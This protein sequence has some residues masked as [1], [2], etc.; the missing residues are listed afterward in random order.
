MELITLKA[1]PFPKDQISKKLEEH[2]ILINGY[3]EEFFAH[4]TF[5]TEHT[6]EMTIAI[7]SLREIGLENGA[8]LDEIFQQIE[9]ISFKPCPTNV[10]IFLRFAWK[11][12]PQSQ[13]SILSGTHHSPDR[14][15][16][17]LSKIVEKD[18]AF[19]KGLYLRN[20]DGN[21]WLRGYVCDSTYRFSGNDLFAFEK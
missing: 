11:N 13:N 7:A 10:G 21:L 2:N 1:N 3:A 15:V 8:M 18:D 4:P 20:V 9:K 5:L 19:P 14:A 12:Q 6:R 16:M 17:V